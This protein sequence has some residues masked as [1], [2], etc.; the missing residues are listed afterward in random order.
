MRIDNFII[1]SFNKIHKNDTNNII[2][3]H[4][5]DLNTNN[6]YINN[7]IVYNFINKEILFSNINIKHAKYPLIIKSHK[8][9][10]IEYYSKNNFNEIKK[11]KAFMNI[12]AFLHIKIR[13][14]KILIKK[15]L[16][17]KEESTTTNNNKEI[18]GNA[19]KS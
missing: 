8:Y 15:Y 4:F 18:L 7:N 3:N 19:I 2:F 13:K 10:E 1:Y 17:K 12:A 6:K 5:K 16:I 9:I 14:I 11:Y